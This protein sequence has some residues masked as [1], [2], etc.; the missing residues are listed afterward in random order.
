MLKHTFVIYALL[1]FGLSGHLSMQPGY[2]AVAS[3]PLAALPQ[4]FSLVQD[5]GT[6][7]YPGSSL[8]TGSAQY[9]RAFM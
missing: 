7:S 3:A 4:S 9:F 2:R 8:S 5:I 6:S 1:I